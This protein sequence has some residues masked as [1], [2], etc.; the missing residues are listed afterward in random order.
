MNDES[1][2]RA[3][4]AMNDAAEK[5][6]R[7]ANRIEEATQQLRV[8]FEDGYGGNALKLIEL[9]DDGKVETLAEYCAQAAKVV[10]TWPQWKQDGADV[11]K[12]TFNGVRP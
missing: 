5:A 7:A 10:E 1:M 4:H 8:L 12:F 6:N 9:L 2:W 3:V 11:T